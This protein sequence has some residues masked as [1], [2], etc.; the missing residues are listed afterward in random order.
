MKKLSIYSYFIRLFGFFAVSLHTKR[1]NMDIIENNIEKWYVIG[2]RGVHHE[3]KVRDDLRKAGFR[4]HVPM[5]YEIKTVRRQEQR[6]LV[7]A[8][9]GLIFAKGTL[10]ALK[11][12]IENVSRD[13]IYIKK[14]TFSNKKDYLTVKDY[15]MERFIEFTNIRQE[16]ITYFKPEELNLEAGETVRIKGGIYDGLEGTVLRI[17]GKKR[18]HIVVQIPGVLIAAVEMEPELLEV[19]TRN[20]VR[21]ANNEIRELPSKDVDG[22]KKLLLKTAEWLVENK[23]DKDVTTTEY[24]LKLIELKRTRARLSKIKGFTPA[25]EAELALPMYMTAVILEEDTAEAEERLKKAI[26]KLKNTSKL[27]KKC[28]EMLEKLKN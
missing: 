14:S 13:L 27:K 21:E 6:T 11:N 10:E 4:S 5:K 9:T 7:P 18:K 12:Y 20:E 1:I 3:E 28:L 16:K 24:N 26:E 23:P 17:K 22:D 8:I 25:T 2:C 15:E 19:K